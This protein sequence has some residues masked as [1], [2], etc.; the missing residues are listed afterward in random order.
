MGIIGLR[1]IIIILLTL[2]L[3]VTHILNLIPLFSVLVM[4]FLVT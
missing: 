4:N 3:K 2:L 1:I